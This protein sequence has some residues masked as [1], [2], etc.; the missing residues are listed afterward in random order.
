MTLQYATPA[1]LPDAVFNTEICRLIGLAGAGDMAAFQR[2][3]EATA[4]RLLRLVRTIVGPDHAEDVM[5]D[6]Y[7]QA[8]RSLPSY[9][10]RRG[11]PM[12]WLVAMARSRALDLLRREKVRTSPPGIEFEP[13]FGASPEDDLLLQEQQAQLHT[14]LRTVLSPKERM[15]LALAYFRDCTQH[16]IATLTGWPVGSVKSLMRRAQAKVRAHLMPAA[17]APVPPMPMPMPMVAAAPPMK[18]VRWAPAGP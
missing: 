10:A 14:A 15:V 13:Q 5:T 3:Y 8:W 6:V 2:L 18:D 12:A 1:R 4:P 9:D 11:E 7:L 17:P 16:E